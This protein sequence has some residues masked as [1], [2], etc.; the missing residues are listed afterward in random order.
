MTAS[1]LSWVK[2]FGKMNWDVGFPRMHGPSI[3]GTGGFDLRSS[4]GTWVV[5]S[6]VRTV[7]EVCYPC[8]WKE[9]AE[10]CSLEL[11]Q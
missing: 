5:L 1:G 9:K 11:Y 6:R 2:G 8:Q 7:L 10:E 3:P 4:G